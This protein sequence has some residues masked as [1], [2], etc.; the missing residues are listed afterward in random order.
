MKR[1]VGYGDRIAVAPGDRIDFRI[2]CEAGDRT[3][4]ADVVRL[5]CG[6]D[7]TT[8]P[9]FRAEPVATSIDGD[10]PGRRQAIHAGSFVEVPPSP[11][12][13]PPAGWSLQAMIWPTLP[14]AGSQTVMGCWSEPAAGYALVIDAAG[15]LALR[16]GGRAGGVGEISTAA[17]LLAREWY[18]VFACWDAATGAVRLVQQPL[19][20]YARADDAGRHEVVAT[21]RPRPAAATPFMLAAQDGGLH[22]ARR[23]APGAYNRKNHPPP[24]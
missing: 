21:V 12:F 11:A 15:C 14:G 3:Y 10:Y 13:A 1:I 20:R 23:V 8:H 7:H 4:R 5:I 18:R 19:R 24:L 16:L 22:G 17:P 9:G 2:N 6:D